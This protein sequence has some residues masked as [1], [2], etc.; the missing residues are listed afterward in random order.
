MECSDE[1]L[2]TSQVESYDRE[3]VEYDKAMK[4]VADAKAGKL[5]A[6]LQAAADAE[7]AAKAAVEAEKWIQQQQH[8]QQQLQQQALAA[9]KSRNRCV[10]CAGIHDLYAGDVGLILPGTCC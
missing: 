6:Q 1:P 9:G 3:K 4:L 2:S 10:G 8:Q 5:P 7:A